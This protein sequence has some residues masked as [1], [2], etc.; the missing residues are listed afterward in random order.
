LTVTA[1][2]SSLLTAGSGTERGLRRVVQ[3]SGDRGAEGVLQ[4]SA[5]AAAC[6]QGDSEFAAC[7]RYQ[8]DWVIPIRLVDGA[9]DQLVLQL[10]SV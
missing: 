9:A 10:R 4:I 2:P 3:L 6:D 7:H 1:S 5:A 8:Q